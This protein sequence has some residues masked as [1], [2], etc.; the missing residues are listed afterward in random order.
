MTLYLVL[1]RIWSYKE[2][3]FDKK[4]NKISDKMM[5][6]ILTHPNHRDRSLQAL[7]ITKKS[8]QDEKKKS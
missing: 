2:K 5:R 4:W 6:N 7:W 1:Q 3:I 8:R